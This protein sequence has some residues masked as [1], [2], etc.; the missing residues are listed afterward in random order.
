VGALSPHLLK[1]KSR[2]IVWAPGSLGYEVA[3]FWTHVSSS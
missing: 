3:A 2:M 1:K